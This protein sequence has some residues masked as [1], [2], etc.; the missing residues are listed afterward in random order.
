M[1]NNSFII[2]TVITIFKALNRFYENSILF[3]NLKRLESLALKGFI[4]GTIYKYLNK[5]TDNNFAE[6]SL[7]I[8]V[9]LKIFATIMNVV[10]KFYL[11]LAGLNLGSLN[12]ALFDKVMSMT[13][14]A[15]IVN[16]K[17]AF[18]VFIILMSIIPDRMW[19]NM[20]IL[21]AAAGYWG[22]FTIQ[23]F[24]GKRDGF[25]A[26]FFPASLALYIFFCIA[27][28]FTGFGGMDS[29]RVA[30][31][32]F[33][34]VSLGIF[35][36]NVIDDMKSFKLIVGFVFV[37]LLLSSFYG[38]LQF[39]GGIEIR[40]DFVDLAT[41]QS[42]PGRL[43]ATMGN[44][45]N[46]AKFIV[47]L[48]PFCF[49][50]AVTADGEVKKIFLMALL[51]PIIVVLMLTFSRASYLAL[52]GAV[53]TFIV[54]IKPRLVPVGI[55]IFIS[56][57]P[58]IPD[59]IIMRMSTVGTDTSSLY[60][61]LIWEGAIRVIEHYWIQGIGI[62]PRAFNLIY[63]AHAHSLAGQAMHSHNVFLNV[64]I[65]IGVGGFIAIVAYNLK[66][67]HGGV[68]TFLQTKN[69][70]NK[71]FLAAGISAL[72]AFLIFS[73]VEHVWFYPRTMLT[74]WIMIGLIWAVIKID[75]SEKRA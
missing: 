59:T 74:Y 14:I 13:A 69:S 25:D 7:I 2:S 43:Y 19:S 52:A 71:Y 29:I 15:S 39:A 26:K 68:S 42:L 56:S 11:V 18:G 46:Y 28:F 35:V 48:L 75:R 31:I 9:V 44:P 70:E 45:N 53:G 3:K 23:Y 10:R 64:W 12:K 24:L 17:V 67:L 8:T 63:R 49:A 60:R 54:I 41:N 73:V 27:S 32:M 5:P 62:G 55:L 47:M 22:I 66:T 1:G 58:L 61:I 51:A 36:I 34:S 20:F 21:A 65:E 72:V 33:A 30:S 40:A 37:G 4:V 38:L 6:G 50:Y 57:I 16:L